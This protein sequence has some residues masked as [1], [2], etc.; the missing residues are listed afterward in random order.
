M[1]LFEHRTIWS[2][3]FVRDRLQRVRIYEAA[4]FYYFLA[5]MAFDWLQFTVI[6]TTPTQK[7]SEWS[8]AGSWLTFLITVLGLL[9]LF[10]M[11]GGRSGEM[12]LYRY[13]P[14]SVSVGWKFLVASF[15][16]V[17]AV[18]LSLS[19]QNRQFVGWADT[20]ALA[21]VNV[22]MFWRI[23]FHLKILACRKEA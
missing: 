2:S 19:G 7:L 12:F 3:R 21:L 15:V 13:F 23:G 9:Y 22:A 14:L 6:G 10:I 8:I 16:T 11:N 5:V 17:A 4:S 18:N 1:P 20:I